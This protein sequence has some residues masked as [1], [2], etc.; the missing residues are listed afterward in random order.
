MNF[1]K[2]KDDIQGLI[3]L[4]VKAK[5]H[6]RMYFGND[7]NISHLEMFVAGYS[8]ALKLN[9]MLDLSYIYGQTG[10]HR[11]KSFDEALDR[12]I[13]YLKGLLNK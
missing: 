5:E 1:Y 8:A 13:V 4:L 10:L 2:S 6:P 11:F 7:Y 12:L 3:D 9:L